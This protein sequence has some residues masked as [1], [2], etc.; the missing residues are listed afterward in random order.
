NLEPLW[1]SASQPSQYTEGPSEPVQDESP[2]EEV[3]PVKAK[4][5]YT[6]RR[7]PLKKS[8]K[9]FVEPWTIEEEIALCK[10][11]VST[12]KNNI[13]GNG[14]KAS[15]FWTEV[16]TLATIKSLKKPCIAGFMKPINSTPPTTPP[17]H[18]HSPLPTSSSMIVIPST[19]KPTTNKP[20]Y[21]GMPSLL[22]RRQKR[23]KLSPT[24]GTMGQ[25][26]SI[27]L[28]GETLGDEEEEYPFVNKYLNFQEE[29]I[30]LMKEKSCPVYDTDNKEGEL[31]P[32][33]DTD[34]EDVIE[35]E[36]GC[37]GKE[38]FGREKDNIEDVVVVDNDLCSSMIQTILSVDF[39]E[40]I[41]TKSHELMSF[42]KSILI[43][44]SK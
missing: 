44:V 26:T 9:E 7:Q 15:G 36:E 4:R 33:Y 18:H 5:K 20:L 14:K 28:A 11:W 3:E 38:G 13:K 43:K 41:N 37:V 27:L 40:D 12:S 10:A 24:S 32:V 25:R 16:G 23:Q 22:T 30:M 35:E 31:M 34:I 39:E 17:L 21:H 8:D 6:R 19:P 42:G 2:V 29:H 1:A